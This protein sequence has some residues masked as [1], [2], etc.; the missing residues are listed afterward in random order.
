MNIAIIIT[1]CTLLL[2]AYVFSITA[3]RTR[4][5]SVILLLLLGWIVRQ[6]ADFLEL[7]I[8]RLTPLLPI[9]GTIGLVLIVLEGSLELELDKSKT[10]IIKKSF[11]VALIPIL[12]LGIT[13]AYLFQYV[14]EAS[15]RV[16]LINAIPLCVISSAIAIPSAKNLSPANKEFSVYESTL[17]DILGVLFFNFMALNTVIDMAAFLHFGL[18]LLIMILVSFVSTIGLSYLLSRID[19]HVKHTPI[20]LLLILIFAVSEVYHLPALIFIVIFGLFMGNFD[21]L[22]RFKWAQQFRADELDKEVSKFKEITM[23]AAFV[24]RALFFLLF[25]YLIETAEILN[26]ETSVWAVGIVALIFLF[27]AVQLKLYGLKLRPLVFLAP[28]GL[29]TI[30]LFFT[31]PVGSTISVVNKSLIMQVIVLSALVMMVGMM[32]TRKEAPEEK[33][34]VTEKDATRSTEVP[35]SDTGT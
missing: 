19:H 18:Q 29:I 21:Q 26:P 11:V 22:K 2:I 12:V 32:T 30:L 34:L 10:P 31:I 25:G 5:P 13:L 24:V 20:I 1:I 14:S 4:I 9:L 23:E 27:R 33:P 17:S 6:A 28:R 16:S 35:Y 7:D 15:L 8:P 3:P